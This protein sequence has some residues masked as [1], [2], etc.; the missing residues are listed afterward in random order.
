MLPK[1]TRR[2]TGYEAMMT[3]PKEP[4]ARVHRNKPNRYGTSPEV[5]KDFLFEVVGK[6]PD[7]AEKYE[8]MRNL[9]TKGH[10]TRDKFQPPTIDD[11]IKAAEKPETL[12]D[13]TYELVLKEL[14]N[15]ESKMFDPLKEKVTANRIIGGMKVSR[16]V[17][18][19]VLQRLL[20]EYGAEK[21]LVSFSKK[22]APSA[23]SNSV[24]EEPGTEQPSSQ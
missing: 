2:V 3:I 19:E 22:L 18:D 9:W 20:Y 24:P 5:F 11:R 8:E 6:I 15:P 17:A 7:C 16:K 1:G 21:L 23:D 10:F 12:T 14:D 4:V 13:K